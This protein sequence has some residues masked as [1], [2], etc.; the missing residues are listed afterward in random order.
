MPTELFY[1]EGFRYCHLVIVT[2]LRSISTFNCHITG[3]V[4]DSQWFTLK[5]NLQLT[6]MLCGSDKRDKRDFPF[7]VSRF[8]FHVLV[9]IE[10]NVCIWTRCTN[11]Y[12]KQPTHCNTNCKSIFRVS[13]NSVREF[14]WIAYDKVH[15]LLLL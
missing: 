6:F 1:Q 7:Y 14:L 10:K 3:P 12:S 4:V 5:W 15:C 9:T 13:I 8:Y 11:F 2:D